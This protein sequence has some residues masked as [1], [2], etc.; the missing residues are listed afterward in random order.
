[1]VG[2]SERRRGSDLLTVWSPRIGLA[3]TRELVRQ[4]RYQKLGASSVVSFLV[5]WPMALLVVQGAHPWLSI[6]LTV[7]GLGGFLGLITAGVMVVRSSKAAQRAADQYW[8]VTP[9]EHVAPVPCDDSA[10]FDRWRTRHPDKTP[11]S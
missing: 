4:R 9:G 5:C 3:A 2:R 11:R 8:N 6:P 1:M 10:S 7:L